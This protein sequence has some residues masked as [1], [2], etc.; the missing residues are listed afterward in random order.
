MDLIHEQLSHLPK[1]DP[2]VVHKL[3]SPLTSIRMYSEALLDDPALT[4]EQKDYLQ[5]IHD[6]S[7]RMGDVITLLDPQHES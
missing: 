6:A 5:E 3:R 7:K 1:L 4:A 2:L